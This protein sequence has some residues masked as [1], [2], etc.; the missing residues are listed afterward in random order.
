MRSP[1][2]KGEATIHRWLSQYKEGGIENLLRNRQLFGYTK[3]FSV[4]VVATLQQELRDPE[5]FHSYK[6][7]HFWLWLIKEIPSKLFD[8][9]T[10]LFIA[11]TP[12]CKRFNQ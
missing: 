6:E 2:G 12:C 5:G 8:I 4:E 3:K 7:V 10:A 11:Q 1:W 9:Q